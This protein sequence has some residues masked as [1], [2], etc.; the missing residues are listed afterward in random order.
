M[1]SIVSGTI[2]S[3]ARSASAVPSSGFSAA[4]VSAI[5]RSTRRDQCIGTPVGGGCDVGSG[6][7]SSVR[8]AG[9]YLD[10]AQR[11]VGIAEVHGSDEMPV[12]DQQRR[13]D[14]CPD[15]QQSR[16]MVALRENRLAGHVATVGFAPAMAD[17]DALVR[18]VRH[19]ALPRDGSVRS[20]PEEVTE[21]R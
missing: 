7:T 16:R 8:P 2:S 20:V 18:T 14:S 6:R 11:V 3:V 9:R 10:E 13:A 5:G 17:V 12:D 21:M 4:S 1:S 19:S 15:G